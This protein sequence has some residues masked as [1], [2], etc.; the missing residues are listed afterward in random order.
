MWDGQPSDA[1]VA[2]SAHENQPKFIMNNIVIN[3]LFGNKVAVE[4]VGDSR[5]YQ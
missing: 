1:I 3:F 5:N 4:L 2:D